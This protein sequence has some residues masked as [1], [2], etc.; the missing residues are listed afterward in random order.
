M[1]WFDFF[2]K[3]K[4][5]KTRFVE[6]YE[7]LFEKKTPS[8]RPLDQLTFI[9]LDTETTGLNPKKDYILS[10]GAIKIKEYKIKVNSAWEIY[11]DSPLSNKESIQI[12]EIL[13]HDQAFPLKEFAKEFLT[14]IGSDILVGHHLGFDI[15]MLEKALRPFGLKKLKNP[16][17]DTL[18]LSMRLEKGPNYDPALGNPGEYALDSLC[19]RYGIPLDDRHTAAGDAFLTAQLLMR[20]LKIADQKGISNFGTL[21]K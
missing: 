7:Q 18:A 2:K 10:F 4:V 5:S 11:L 16:V 3:N 6:E 12:H 21:I 20:L 14:Y 19:D 17:I 9:V 1:G 13:Y 15:A 8:I